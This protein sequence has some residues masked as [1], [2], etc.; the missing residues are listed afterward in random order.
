MPRNDAFTF[1]NEKTPGQFVNKM[2]NILV[3]MTDICGKAKK[4]ASGTGFAY[5]DK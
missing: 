5:N 4:L 2:T 1:K 3:K